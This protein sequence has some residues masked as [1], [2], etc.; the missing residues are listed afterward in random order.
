MNVSRM[1]EENAGMF[2]DAVILWD[3][4]LEKTTRMC[5]LISGVSIFIQAYWQNS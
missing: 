3:G 4:I 5:V 1:V 2:S